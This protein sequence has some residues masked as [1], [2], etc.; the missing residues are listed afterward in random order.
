MF[1]AEMEKPSIPEVY[2]G[3]VKRFLLDRT[4]LHFKITYNV[5]ISV[6]RLVACFIHS[7]PRL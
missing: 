3:Y 2:N 6:P 4:P 5:R 7:P 1:L